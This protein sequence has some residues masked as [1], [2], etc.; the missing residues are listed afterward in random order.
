MTIRSYKYGFTLKEIHQNGVIFFI[1]GMIKYVPNIFSDMKLFSFIHDNYAV[2]GGIVI[3]K[4]CSQ[5]Y[6]TSLCTS[7]LSET[8][9]AVEFEQSNKTCW[10]LSKSKACTTGMKRVGV[11]HYR[12][13]SCG[14]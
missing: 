7:L 11:S 1:N 4:N 14:E 12:R 6:C 5:A 13:G 2:D 8:C 9:Y 3:C 10:V